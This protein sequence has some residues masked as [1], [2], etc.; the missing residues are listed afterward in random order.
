MRLDPQPSIGALAQHYAKRAEA[1][2]YQ[3][4]TSIE[5]ARVDEELFAYLVKQSGRNG[6]RIFDI[7]CFDGQLLDVAKRQ[8]WETF[9]LEFQGPAADVAASPR[10]G[11]ILAVPGCAGAYV[12][13]L[14]AHV[15]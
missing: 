14:C 5:R 9:G 1:G 8:G 11:P 13:F 4:G 7:G 3:P 10:D 6:G 2:N 15:K 12:L